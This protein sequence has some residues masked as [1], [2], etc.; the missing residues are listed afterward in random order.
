LNMMDEAMRKG[1]RI[2]PDILAGRLGA[3][4]VPVTARRNQGLDQVMGQ[5]SMLVSAPG[6]GGR[7]NIAYAPQLEQAIA[8]LE[9]PVASLTDCAAGSRWL[10]LRLLEQDQAL[11]EYFDGR[12]AGSIA[13]DPVLSAELTEI[14]EDFG[15]GGLEPQDIEYLTAS[16]LVQEAEEIYRAAVQTAGRDYNV[17]D[18]KIDRLLTGRRAGYPLMLALLALVFWLTINGANYPSQWLA[19]GLFWL[20]TQLGAL[21]LA[22]G[23]PDWLYGALILGVYRTL[24]WVVSVMLPPMAI[25]FPLFTLL[26][27]SGYLPR[28]AFNLDR[29]FQKC[30][31][32]GKQALTMC[33]G[34]GCNAAGVTGCRIIDSPRERLIAIITNCFVPCNGRFPALIALITMFFIGSAGGFWP[35]V[36]SALFL[37]AIIIF[38]IAVTFFV[39]RLLSRT[40]LRGVPSSFTLEL[41]PY[42]RPQ[43]AQV[44]VRSLLDRTLFVLGRAVKVAAPAGLV[45]WLLA[46]IHLGGISWLSYCANFLDPLAQALGMDGVILLAFILGAPANEIVLPIII[47]GYL[48]QGSLSEMDSL[49]SLRRLFIEN[50]W[51]WI[52]AGSTMLFY[53]IHWPCATTSLTIYK[54]TQSLKWTL[55]SIFVPTI[56][57]L[58]ICFAFANAARLFN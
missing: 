37:T 8:R 24:A 31:A 2:A 12:P 36:T 45:I 46:N 48:S 44:I 10:S 4:V 52:T 42:R 41:P 32:C 57:G 23:A 6:A 17:A 5:I 20:E 7:R 40:I 25:F 58:L 1:I 50:G 22:C 21:L 13:Q 33:M 9:P 39:S 15:A 29:H 16:A 26:E 30:C 49:L 56:M 43:F 27:D 51:T 35:S 18:R 11:P 14:W 54:E 34:F 19:G 38:S 28:V 47:M 3:P 53:L 55:I